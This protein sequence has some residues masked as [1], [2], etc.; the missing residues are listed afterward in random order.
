LL[1]LSAM[2]SQQRTGWWVAAV[3]RF[4]IIRESG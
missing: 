1:G 3:F 4:V 2:A